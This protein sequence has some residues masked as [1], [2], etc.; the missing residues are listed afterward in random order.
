M[1]R[2]SLLVLLLG[3]SLILF[4]LSL[5][6]CKGEPP[7]LELTIWA[8]DSHNAGISRSYEGKTISCSDPLFDDYMCISYADAKKIGETILKCKVWET[9]EEEVKRRE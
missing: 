6:G 7:A 5:S 9:S 1:K 3:A 2:Q 8:G 4:S